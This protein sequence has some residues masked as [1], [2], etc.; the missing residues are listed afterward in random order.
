MD[1]IIGKR[2]KAVINGKKCING[3]PYSATITGE[4]VSRDATVDIYEVVAQLAE[5][6]RAQNRE[7]EH[8]RNIRI[9]IE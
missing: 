3:K 7:M 5:S 1:T 9:T 2:F 4:I 8:P 6:L